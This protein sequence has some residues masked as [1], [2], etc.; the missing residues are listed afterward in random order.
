MGKGKV[1]KGGGSLTEADFE[2][3]AKK[4]DMSLESTK[5]ETLKLLKKQLGE[6]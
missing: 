4:W 6:K 1:S 5:K 3:M 2:F